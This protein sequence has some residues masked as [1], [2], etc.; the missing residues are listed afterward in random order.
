MQLCKSNP[1]PL[2][3]T[4]WKTFVMDD[5]P[6]NNDDEDN[7]RE[8]EARIGGQLARLS[9]NFAALSRLRRTA[10]ATHILTS[11]K[12]SLLMNSSS[13]KPADFI[14]HRLVED[15]QA[16]V[17]GDVMNKATPTLQLPDPISY[18]S[19]DARPTQH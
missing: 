9:D 2:T 14:M 15:L 8:G 18:P 13:P 3:L 7:D 11:I 19:P 10:T 17:P 16:H 12:M 6:A 5:E 4:L 1:D